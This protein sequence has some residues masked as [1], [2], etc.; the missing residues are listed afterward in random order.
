LL[1]KFLGDYRLSYDVP[2]GLTV[3]GNN[4]TR[5]QAMPHDTHDAIVNDW[6]LNA[7]AH[8]DENYSFL[9]G[10]KRRSSKMVDRVARQLHQ[11][12]FQI[13]DCTRCANCCRTLQPSFS[14]EEIDRIAD[15]LGK[16]REEFIAA[17]LELDNEKKQYQT[18]TTP[19]PL[20]GE[21]GRC[22]VY[23]VR[24]RECRDYPYTDKKDFTCHTISRA[25]GALDCPA[26]FAIVEGIKKRLR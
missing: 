20:L 19:C 13:I 10:L 6:K 3:Y 14:D 2:L 7:Q 18:R 25:Q 1:S 9:R 22:T 12:V 17:Y 21:D 11:D 15:Y 16:S 4:H 5:H 24:P 8:D 26:A 23:E